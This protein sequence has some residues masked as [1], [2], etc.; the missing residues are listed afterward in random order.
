MDF[1]AIIVALNVFQQGY[2]ARK[3]LSLSRYIYTCYYYL[4]YKGKM[5]SLAILGVFIPTFFFVSIT[6]GMCMT[7]ALSLGMSIG[8]KR[9]LWMMLG[10][11]IGIGLVATATIIGVAS[12]I[13]SYPW[14]FTIFKFIGATY[15][16]YLG[17]MMLQSKGKLA[18]G[19]ENNPTKKQHNKALFMQGFITAIANPKGWAFMI[20][21]LP[22]FINNEQ[23]LAQQMVILVAI[24]LTFEFIC[25]SLY[26]AGGKGL[27]YL[28]A[29]AENVRLI[30]R[31]SGSL[32]IGVGVWLMLT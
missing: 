26:A 27:K 19:T 4:Y 28:L 15:L 22:P 2:F 29:S 12:V 11:I 30:N 18:I 10:E 6:P 32:M 9:T 7:L 24:I 8:Y 13:S 25:M 20:S 16:L 17:V 3:L 21:L 1:S 5:M 14:L 23:P 31:I